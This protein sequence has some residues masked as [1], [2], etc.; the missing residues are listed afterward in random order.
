MLG[1]TFGL[2]IAFAGLAA[3]N[4]AIPEAVRDILPRRGEIGIDGVVLGFALLASLATSML[5]GLAPA[6]ALPGATSIAR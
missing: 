3:L 1:G 5:C 2:A 4:A 6:L